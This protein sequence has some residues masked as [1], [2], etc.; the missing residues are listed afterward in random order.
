MGKYKHC[1][2]LLVIFSFGSQGLANAFQICSETARTPV[3]SQPGVIEAAPGCHQ[4]K[5]E[6]DNS[7]DICDARHC[8]P[9]VTF[10]V[11]YL[12]G[13][14]LVSMDKGRMKYPSHTYIYSGPE[15]IFHP[16]KLSL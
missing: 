10:S 12:S 7:P 16:P 6:T 8:C 5:A 2:L 13:H 3:E 9:G 11:V 15:D 1:L 4:T 14:L